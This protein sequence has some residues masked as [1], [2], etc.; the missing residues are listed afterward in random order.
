MGCGASVN[1]W[2][3]PSALAPRR[4]GIVKKVLSRRK[5]SDSSE[6]FPTTHYHHSVL[7]QQVKAMCFANVRRALFPR[8]SSQPPPR[9]LGRRRGLHQSPRDTQFIEHRVRI[10]SDDDDD[11]AT[12]KTD[13]TASTRLTTSSN[14]TSKTHTEVLPRRDLEAGPRTF[15][16]IAMDCNKRIENIKNFKPKKPD[17]QPKT[18]FVKPE[19]KD[20]LSKMEA[21][22]IQHVTRREF[23]ENAALA[24]VKTPPIVSRRMITPTRNSMYGSNN[25]LSSEQSFIVVHSTLKVA[26]E[27]EVCNERIQE[28]K[29]KQRLKQGNRWHS[30]D[31]SCSG[32]SES[33]EGPDPTI[34]Y[35]TNRIDWSRELDEIV[36]LD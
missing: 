20:S 12:N 9:R 27:K 21:T 32:S 26:W 33:A 2:P 19:R 14:G 31:S 35:G 3:E 23:L 7:D 22:V 10:E 8:K 11:A 34:V 18:V 5:G 13:S 4:G 30:V 24:N 25:T 6:D 17:S 29:R 16:R 28:Q 15:F 1:H 36:R